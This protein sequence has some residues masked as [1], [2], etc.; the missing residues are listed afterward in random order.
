MAHQ[1]T[2]KKGIKPVTL[3]LTV[4]AKRINENGTFSGFEVKSV[5]GPNSTFKAAIP[6]QG[7]G[8]IYLKVDSMEG[9]TVLPDGDTGTATTK[10]KLF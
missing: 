8:A 9:L 10:V 6:P 1:A 4:E 3:T 2:S 7:G 5:K